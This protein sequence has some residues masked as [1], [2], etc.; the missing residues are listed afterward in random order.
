MAV[1][2]IVQSDVTFDPEAGW[3]I[4]PLTVDK[5]EYKFE[6]MRR[7]FDKSYFL[8]YAAG[9]WV[10]AAAR[11]RLWQCIRKIDNDLVYTDTDSLFYLNDHNWDWFNDDATRRLQEMCEAR[12]IDFERTRPRVFTFVAIAVP[13]EET[14]RLP[15]YFTSVATAVPPDET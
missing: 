5:V 14:N 3:N 10:T 4:E 15:P 8:H 2:N 11:H 6:K 12:D 1:S 9:C 13:P 7:W